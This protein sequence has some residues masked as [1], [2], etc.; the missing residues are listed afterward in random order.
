MVPRK[1][2]QKQAREKY[3]NK[4]KYTIIYNIIILIIYIIN[5]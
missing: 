5:I 3:N 1:W 2:D 4:F